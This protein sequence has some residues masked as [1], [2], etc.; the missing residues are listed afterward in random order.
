MKIDL[1]FKYY[2]LLKHIKAISPFTPDI[3]LILGSGLGDFADS[4]KIHK[5]F[6]TA[7]LPGYPPS[8]VEGHSGKI[9]FCEYNGKKLLLFQGRIHLYEGYEI[10][11]TVLPVF[12]SYKTG[13]RNM[14]ITNAAGGVNPV[15]NPGNLMLANSFMG[16]S[17]KKELTRLIGLAK[18]DSKILMLDFPSGEINNKIRFAAELENITL[19]EGVYWYNKGPSYET[20]AEVIMAAKMGADA[21]GMSTVHEAVFAAYLEMKVASIS[22][23]TN[24]A[25]GISQQKLSHDEVTETANKVKG[26]F[27]RLIKKTVE[28]I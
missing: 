17:I 25:A 18:P 7:T 6:S 20:P 14:I 11:E 27:E 24:Y 21:V 1:Y 13:C 2:D 22:C 8:T 10:Y 15:Y 26:D 19:R 4:L 12:I 23:I 5:S 3:S 16:I 9:H 28:L